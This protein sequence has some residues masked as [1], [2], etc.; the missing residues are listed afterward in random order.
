[1]LEIK[2]KIILDLTPH[3]Y[4]Y[5]ITYYD[6]KVFSDSYRIIPNRYKNSKEGF[7]CGNL[8]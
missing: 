7:L 2:I 8:R 6:I 4:I 5:P 3:K 1:M